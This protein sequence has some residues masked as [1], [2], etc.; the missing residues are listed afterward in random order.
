MVVLVSCV[1]ADIVRELGDQVDAS[2]KKFGIQLDVDYD[3]LDDIKKDNSGNPS[4]CMLDLVV[5]WTSR[6]PGTGDLPRTWETVVRAV[7]D[8]GQRQLADRLGKK[9]QV[10][11]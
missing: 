1:L 5:R 9:Y 11:L 4:D 3:V 10:E 2:W 6:K 7:R 8:A